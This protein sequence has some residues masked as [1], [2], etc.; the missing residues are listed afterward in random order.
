MKTPGIICMVLAL[1]LYK[2]V[3]AQPVTGQVSV[4]ADTVQTGKKDTLPG[5]LIFRGQ[6]SGWAGAGIQ[7]V[8]AGLRYLPQL[9]FRIGNP[10][11]SRGVRFEGELAGNL[12]AHL[13]RQKGVTGKDFQARRYRGWVRIAGS[14]SELRLGLQKINFGPALM[15]RPLMWFDSMD[16]RDPLQLTDGVWGALGR[17]YFRNNVNLWIWGLLGNDRPRPLDVGLS[18]ARVPEF[19]ARLQIPIATGSA[20]FSFHRRKTQW[21]ELYENRYGLD[22]RL[23]YFIG[24]W[25]EATWINKRGAAG[26]KT[27]QQL[28]MVGADYTVGLGNGLNVIVEHMLASNSEKPFDLDNRRHMSALSINYPLGLWDNVG[29]IFYLDWKE[30]RTYH[31]VRWKH[32]MGFGDLYVM[33]YANPD[34]P[35]LPDSG[36]TAGSL[37][38]K[39]I[40]IMLVLSHQTK[41]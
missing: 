30:K 14:R 21:Q 12:Y 8:S 31:F 34:V 10:P 15:L 36:S 11:G 19:G 25:A 5:E 7:S 23:D 3:W 22:L 40:R 26:D 28:W 29:Y 13:N 1:S 37:P 20:G 35:V 2:A 33:A 4:G 17:Y 41:L 16:P 9:T 6:L 27:N 24:F 32:V 39:G 18:S 38:G